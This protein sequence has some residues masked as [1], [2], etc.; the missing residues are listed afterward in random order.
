MRI[1]RLA[2]ALA[3]ASTRILIT[4]LACA[5]WCAAGQP[6]FDLNTALMGCTFKI[7]GEGSTGTAFILGRPFPRNPAMARYVLITAA[8]VLEQMA[9]ESATVVL[10]EK[11]DTIRWEPAPFVLQIRDGRRQLWTKHPQADVAVMYVRLPEG[12]IQQLLPASVLADD[13]VLGDLEVHPGEEVNALGYPLG[14]A[15]SAGGFP[16]LRSGKVASFPLLPTSQTKTFLLDFP[17]F[18]GNSGGPV[19]F[20]K[21]GT[22]V[23]G[24]AVG[25]GVNM[26]FIVGLVSRE[27][28]ATEQVRELFSRSERNYPLGLAEVVHSSLIKDAIDLLPPPVDDVAIFPK[29]DPPKK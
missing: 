12:A 25:I 22:R 18:P 24:G 13:K 17:V 19:Y 5:S 11:R 9:G 4:V 15:S 21:S 6:A 16:V 7:Y 29:S 27:M 26:N 3:F 14:F 1:P 8:H 20:G 23:F 2:L 10:R 28:S